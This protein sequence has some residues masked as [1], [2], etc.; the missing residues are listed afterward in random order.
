MHTEIVN[1]G[2]LLDT[3][4]K[5]TQVGWARHQLLDCNL[6]NAH[7]YALKPL[8]F[9]RVK[10]WDYYATF[11]PRRFFSATV[12]DLGYAGNVF[13][14]TL[15][16]E[17]GDLH[18][19]GLVIPLGK[20]IKLPRNSTG[21]VTSYTSKEA[22]LTFDVSENQRKLSVDWP[23]FNNGR[24][25]QAELTLENPPDYESMTIVIP[26]GKKR[27]YY[28]RKIN[29]LPVQGRI[30][31]GDEIEELR[32]HESLGSLD[33]GRGVWE[34]SSFWNWASTSGFLPD[35]RRV[36]LNLGQGFGDTSQATEDCLILDNRIHKL[37]DVRFTY[38]ADDFMAP[39]HFSDQE[40]RLD[41][42]FVPFKDRPAETHLLI[43]DS[44]V[45]QMF[46]RYSGKVVADDGEEIILD[47]LIGFAE[48]HHARW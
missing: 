24:G 25:I 20:N 38:N 37:S 32:P 17:S 21:G 15:D 13:V 12:A 36:G 14:Y 9:L 29:C 6:E 2:A 7:F 30:Q 44:V 26:I 28:N 22:T 34:Y 10:R 46:G 11:T 8:Q 42:E 4:G 43:I 41:L 45:H 40:G 47:G 16:F 19:E 48:E 5:L 39:W 23:G 3:N 33:W 1:A 35:G 27:F 31:Y 18:E